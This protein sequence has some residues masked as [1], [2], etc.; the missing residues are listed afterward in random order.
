M[1]G[2]NQRF[3]LLLIMLIE[4]RW[5]KGSRCSVMT[6]FLYLFLLLLVILLFLFEHFVLMF[7]SS[8]RM[9]Y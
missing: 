5:E 1:K 4:T 8:G 2:A 6:V 3:Q 7:R 9:D